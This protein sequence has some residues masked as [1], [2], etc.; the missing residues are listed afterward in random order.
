MPAILEA[1]N[2]RRQENATRAHS[3]IDRYPDEVIEADE[4]DLLSRE[5]K[6]GELDTRFRDRGCNGDCGNEF[7]RRS[8]FLADALTRSFEGSCRRTGLGAGTLI[9]SLRT[10]RVVLIIS[11]ANIDLSFGDN[12]FPSFPGL[13]SQTTF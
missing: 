1:C 8:A 2:V 3:A 11:V 10:F 6:L 4:E 9:A 12:S 7:D 5:D 13:S